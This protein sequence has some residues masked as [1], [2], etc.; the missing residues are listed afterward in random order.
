MPD[1]DKDVARNLQR[2]FYGDPHGLAQYLIRICLTQTGAVYE[3]FVL[4]DNY[5]TLDVGCRFVKGCDVYA[6][7]KTTKGL[8]LCRQ[9]HQWLTTIKV[10]IAP[11][12]CANN[13]LA[14][15]TLKAAIDAAK[16]EKEKEKDKGNPYYTIDA[17]IVLEAD[18]LAV[19]DK[20]APLYFAKVGE[21]FN[22]NSGTRDSF[23][24]AEA[25]YT[26]YT[27]G[28]KTLHLY[29]NR[30]VANELIEIIKN[31]QRTGKS[32]AAI[33]QTMAELIQK[34]FEQNV[35]MSSHQRA[36]AIDI[37]INGDI[38]IK[39]MT[40][41]QQKI[42]MEIAAKVTGYKALLERSP[43]HIHIKFK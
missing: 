20:I 31:G 41:A 12:A 24:Q 14:L 17:S 32:K 22:V 39:P 5:S 27:S 23:R 42:M 18:A 7:V 25:M 9:L 34:Y 13:A 16:P 2:K 3:L 21:K 19:L 40:A 15:L 37:D 26:V 29:G 10:V 11:T 33:V 8:F 38:G 28:D 43:P 1:N 4:L 35:L 30:K 6:L 36:G